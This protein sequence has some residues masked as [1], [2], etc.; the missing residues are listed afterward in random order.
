MLR[1]LVKGDSR[2]PV[3]RKVIHRAVA[4]LLKSYQLSGK[5]E[6]SVRIGGDRLLKHL[7][8][9][10]RGL[11]YPAEVLSFS[12]QETGQIHWLS[13][14]GPSDKFKSLTGFI[15]PPNGVLYLGDVVISYPQARQAAARENMLVENKIA[16]LVVHGVKH[17]LGE[18]H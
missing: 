8:H 4:D 17:L 9:S 18:H 2:F 11:D 3:S 1:V 10:Y 15:T 13:S 6:V 7:N 12:Q 14:P 16:E 5:I